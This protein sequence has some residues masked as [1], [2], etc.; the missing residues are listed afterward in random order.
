[1]VQA[2]QQNTAGVGVPR[3]AHQTWIVLDQSTSTNQ[4]VEEAVF[5][6]V[7]WNAVIGEPYDVLGVYMY[8]TIGT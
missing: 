8:L 2:F 3:N 5:N 7:V 6:E 4:Q 1:M